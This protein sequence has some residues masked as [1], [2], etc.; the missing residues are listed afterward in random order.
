[1]TIVFEGI[2]FG[3]VLAFLIGP[4]FFT[5]IQTSIE[6]GFF[7][8]MMIAI[9]VSM[10]DLIYVSIC[11]FGLISLV[12]NPENAQYLGYGGGSVLMI[13]G[14]YHVF[15]KGRSKSLFKK[16]ASN[17]KESGAMRYIL[18]GFIINGFSPTVLFFWVATV[19]SLMSLGY[20]E[21]TDFSIFFGA[22]LATV[23]LTDILKA[24]L[25]DKLRNLV[26]VRFIRISNI[27]LGIVLFVF[28]L[29][30]VLGQAGILFTFSH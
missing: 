27:I 24:F 11:Y 26:T 23:L 5:L 29:R 19:G 16:V 30:L 4:V 28:G 25:A 7:Y 6:K 10:S 8:G 1:M 20:S 22:L 12:N 2:Q 9:G 18:K 13:F 17:G 14:A 3:L 15:V 21:G